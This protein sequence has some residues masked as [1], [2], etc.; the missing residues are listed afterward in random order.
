[1]AKDDT[2]K[3]PKEKTAAQR[4]AELDKDAA[5]D[6][7]DAVANQGKQL[8]DEGKQI[9]DQATA[10]AAGGVTAD[11]AREMALKY[12]G[13]NAQKLVAAGDQ[14]KQLQNAT[15]G[16]TPDFKALAASAEQMGVDGKTKEFLHHLADSSDPARAGEVPGLIVD[17]D[18][19]K[20]KLF[21]I[22][23][24][25]VPPQY[26]AIMASGYTFALNLING[27]V[28]D[29]AYK[30]ASH[31][32]EHQ[33]N[34]DAA[35]RHRAGLVAAYAGIGA[36]T[37]WIDINQFYQA[38][39]QYREDYRKLSRHLAP[40][41]D[42]MKGHH[43]TAAL[44]S[45]KP[46]E[47]ELVY[48]ER[49]RMHDI[50]NAE[51]NKH[52]VQALG[53]NVQFVVSAVEGHAKLGAQGFNSDAAKQAAKFAKD[54][55]A[56]KEHYAKL[57][58]TMDEIKSQVGDRIS[59]EKLL[60][61]AEEQIGAAPK[62]KAKADAK[63]GFS[64]VQSQLMNGGALIS[65][66][67]GQMVGNALFTSRRDKIQ[68]ISAYD[69]IR[70]LKAQVDDNTKRERYR[71]PTGMKVEGRKGVN[72]NALTLEHYI[73]QIFRQH[74]RD[75][76]PSAK[77]SDR[78]KDEFEEAC[79]II[80]QEIRDERLD[81]MAL[82]QL[83]GERK[84]VRRGG[85]SVVGK[86]VVNAEVDR[87]EAQMKHASFIDEAEYFNDASFSK[88]QLRDAWDAMDAEEREIFATFV[89][90][91]VLEAAGVNLKKLQQDKAQRREAMHKNVKQVV[92]GLVKMGDEKMRELDATNTEI[93]LLNNAAEK[94]AKEG[95]DAID[96]YMPGVGKNG[97]LTLD[98]PVAN[99]LV[100]HVQH[101]G[102]LQELM[103][104]RSAE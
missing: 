77:I 42:D 1:M 98:R 90:E 47:N 94:V 85:K 72:D 13:D 25:E 60:E 29:K 40:V 9:A 24:M 14:L 8:A 39:K 38:E 99:M 33:F 88:E 32:A 4:L 64:N 82:I 70:E 22:E 43:G 20:V 76:D 86:D 23:G 104:E 66:F 46:D 101:G 21:G 78:L 75:G 67:V 52:F 19:G 65:T 97:E 36:M 84:V 2:E 73:E 7:V 50:N 54:K 37:H 16:D 30:G 103:I 61:M 80:A 92:D 96:K 81:T 10:I 59:K 5:P 83:V 51:R 57:A 69:M 62:G 87:I 56:M 26:A 34:L 58:E 3:Q 6:A 31:V 48:N 11:A 49:R 63:G 55:D 18:S 53:R 93:E 68:P 71:L 44:F 17:R 79:G 35:G 100:H 12:G 41:L 27:F 95:D 91:E 45:V 89:P 74:E 15:N 102:R 28:W